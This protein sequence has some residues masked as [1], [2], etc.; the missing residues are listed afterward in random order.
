VSVLKAVPNVLPAAEAAPPGKVGRPLSVAAGRAIIAATE[1]VLAEAG[2]G[3]LNIERVAQRA[4]VTR[5][6]IYRRWISKVDLV[7]A[8]LAQRDEFDGEGLPDT[9][10]VRRD[11]VALAHRFAA[12]Q[13]PGP[14]YLHSLVAGAQ[15]DAKLAE[16]V[17]AYLGSHRQQAATIIRRA[18]DRG[19]LRADIDAE[20]LADL[21]YGFAWYRRLIKRVA[22]DDADYERVI[23][24]LLRSAWK[25]SI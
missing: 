23:D 20:T 14:P 22:I 11:L 4:G 7:A 10:S 5:Q 17:D 2:Y 9:G 16:V 19:E 1:S 12:R 8:V 21:F 13:R 3:G 18:R 25:E 24:T 6:T 15:Y